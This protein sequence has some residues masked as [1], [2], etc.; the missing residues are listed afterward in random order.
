[1]TAV[2]AHAAS[3]AAGEAALIYRAALDAG[4]TTLDEVERDRL[5]AAADLQRAP[6]PAGAVELSIR[7]HATREFGLVLSAGAGGLDAALDAA[8]F[9][10]DR[11]AVHAAVELTDGMDFLERFKRTI[12]WQRIAALC[13]RRGLEAPTAALAQLLDAALQLAAGG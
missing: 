5:L 7:I 10:R 8:N 13:V 3:R 12:A 4:R 9:A 2:Q 11:A 6:A 1:M